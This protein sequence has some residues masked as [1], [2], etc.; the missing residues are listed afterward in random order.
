[1]LRHSGFTV[2]TYKDGVTFLDEA[3]PEDSGCILLD[4]RMPVMDGLEASK[5]IRT[6]PEFKHLAT[7]PIVALSAHAAEQSKQLA[8]RAGVDHYLTKPFEK[9]ELESV[10]RQAGKRAGTAR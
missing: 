5:I 4:V 3:G 2:K 6:S 8:F 10:L 9:S 7:V 1:M